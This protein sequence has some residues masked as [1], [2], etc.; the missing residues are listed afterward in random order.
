MKYAAG[1]LPALLVLTS[2]DSPE[3]REAH[4]AEQRLALVKANAIDKDEICA[5][6][7]AV[8]DAWLKALDAHKY[9]FAKLDADSTCLEASM[10]R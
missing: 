3:V 2:C 5:A 7:R 8:A 9:Q 1:L 10:A 4:R 6:S